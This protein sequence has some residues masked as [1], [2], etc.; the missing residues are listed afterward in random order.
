MRVQTMFGRISAGTNEKFFGPALVL[1]RVAFGATLAKFSLEIAWAHGHT[2]MANGIL[3][4]DIVRSLAVPHASTIS[5]LV[6]PL[7]VVAV[8][9]VLGLF[10]KPASILIF[11]ILAVIDTVLLPLVTVKTIFWPE[12]MMMSLALMGLSGGLGH[13]AGLNGLILRN[14]SHPGMIVRTLFS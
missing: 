12:L 2:P 14:I 11:I 4:L 7:L 9:F 10:T 5:W 6:L 3:P 8:C 13:A 1:L